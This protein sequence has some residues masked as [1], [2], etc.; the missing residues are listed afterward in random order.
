MIIEEIESK[1][2]PRLVIRN[3]K[4]RIFFSAGLIKI[5]I[6]LQNI[7]ALKTFFEK[8][9]KARTPVDMSSIV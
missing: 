7:E 5:N 9:K 1:K 3:E 6:I 2:Q 4:D 8:H